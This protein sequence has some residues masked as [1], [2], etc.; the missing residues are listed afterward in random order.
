MS[1][2]ITDIK[3]DGRVTTQRLDALQGE[4]S[5]NTAN[6]IEGIGVVRVDLIDRIDQSR[7]ELGGKVDSLRGEM[8]GRLD[9]V[10]DRFDAVKESLASAKVWAVMVYVAL[11]GSLLFVMARGFKWM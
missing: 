10:N 7:K 6:L 3:A 8:T 2:G 11:V 4:V 9:A 1:T 5:K